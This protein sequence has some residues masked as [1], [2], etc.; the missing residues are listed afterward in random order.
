MS[1]IRQRMNIPD[2]AQSMQSVATTVRRQER[3]QVIS[4]QFPRQR[5]RHVFLS[6][7]QLTDFGP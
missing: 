5:K 4:G 2:A 1:V 6:A 7:L 3:C